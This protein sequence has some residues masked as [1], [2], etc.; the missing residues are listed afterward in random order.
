[1][2]LSHSTSNS[3]DPELMKPAE[4]IVPT[5]APLNEITSAPSQLDSE[6][7]DFDEWFNSLDES[8]IQELEMVN[9]VQESSVVSTLNEN[10]HFVISASCE[11]KPLQLLVDTGSVCSLLK[12][13]SLPKEAKVKPSTQSLS[14]ISGHKLPL[15]GESVLNL[16]MGGKEIPI[17]FQIGELKLRQPLDGLI[18]LSALRQNG[19]I[20]NAKTGSFT[21][22]KENLEASKESKLSYVRVTQDLNFQPGQESLFA[23]TLTDSKGRTLPERQEKAVFVEHDTLSR[24]RNGLVGA[25]TVSYVQKENEV[26]VRLLNLNSSEVFLEKGTIIG[27]ARPLSENS[28]NC[29][30]VDEENFNEKFEVQKERENFEEVKENSE[31]KSPLVTLPMSKG[32]PLDFEEATKNVPEPYAGR[33]RQLLEE[34]RD[35]FATS[36][37]HIGKYKDFI[38]DIDLQEGAKPIATKQ[39]PIPYALK[40]EAKKCVQK[41][42]E[43]GIIEETKSPW[44]SP[45]LL[46][47]SKSR[48]RLVVDYRAVNQVIRQ[49]RFPLQPTREIFDSLQGSK[50]FSL[51]DSALAYHQIVISPKSKEITAFSFDN[52]SYA[53]NRLPFGLAVSSQ[54]YTRCMSHLLRDL[55]ACALAFVD[56]LIVFSRDYDT[57]LIHLKHVFNAIRRSGML[58]NL[59]KCKLMLKEVPYLGSIINE[60]GSR[61]C[62]E[63]IKVIVDYPRPKSQKELLAALG[64]F[65]YYRRHIKGFS[66]IAAPLLD[67]TSKRT[68]PLFPDVVNS[69]N[70]PQENAFCELKHRLCTAPILAFPNPNFEYELQTDA[71]TLGLSY[72]LCQRDENGLEHV[73]AY[74][75]RRLRPN[76]TRRSIIELETLA[77]LTGCLHFKPYLYGR[78][79][80]L[81]TDSKS[82]LW[83]KSLKYTNSKLFR[84]SMTLQEFSFTVKHR[85]SKQNSNCDALSRNFPE[86]DSVNAVEN[87]L[88]IIDQPVKPTDNLIPII[89]RYQILEAQTED[90]LLQP[91]IQQLKEGKA[92]ATYV[93][94]S[95][96]IL[97][98]RHRDPSK[99]L[100]PE[101]FQV[102]LPKALQRQVLEQCHNYPFGL[103]FSTEKTLQRLQDQVY[104]KS[105]SSDVKEFCE[106]CLNCKASRLP[107]KKLLIPL[108]H[109]TVA[110]LPF[111][112]LNLD[113]VGPLPTSDKGYKYLLVMVDQL[114]RFTIAC[115]LRSM[116]AEETAK[117][118]VT[119]VIYR[120]GL[121]D[122]IL[123]DRGS[124]FISELFKNVCKLLGIK[125]LLSSGYHPQ[126]SGVVERQNKTIAQLLR[127]ALANENL[128]LGPSR[129]AI[130]I[131]LQ[132][133]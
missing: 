24:L 82:L 53:Y 40:P 29:L 84:W 30:Y 63:K 16:N 15:S 20:L 85:S 67:L 103:H 38:V 102:L 114:T 36:P 37:W 6:P 133:H 92:H 28:A 115:P 80:T 121:V 101:K 69:W 98:R 118:F 59:A 62:P 131:S 9:V 93:L 100:Q 57:Q 120:Y 112:S 4:V 117:K 72:I 122:A 70:E 96:G 81:V 3:T 11:G 60:H 35:I 90:P 27:H 83:V 49:D 119:N 50:V 87:E 22:E 113:L 46:V 45:V 10:N 13:N 19:V 31:E 2:T 89:N 91:I 108:Q 74:G 105:M 104:W 58:L 1:M 110:Y 125:Q 47:K 94:Q 130:S 18:G 7:V 68:N 126:T 75:S 23:A 97:C 21:F 55:G 123:T 41:L 32:K 56:D 48:F 124:N 42:L 78:H 52:R 88:E 34:Y 86:E 39:Y 109:Q 107:N 66:Q 128:N 65:S 99:P 64:L 95:D 44:N 76:E 79:F 8:D 33:L 54:S 12:L 51:L 43:M 5:P 111:N 25:S 127:A 132:Y 106:S 71:S 73:I 61:P 116:S 26:I 14:S 77:C 129:Q 17:L